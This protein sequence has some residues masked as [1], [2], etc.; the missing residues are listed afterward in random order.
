[1][2]LYFTD[3]QSYTKGA[4]KGN[5][6]NR[7]TQRDY[8]EC[9]RRC[10]LSNL[11]YEVAW[12]RREELQAFDDMS[13][14]VDT[15]DYQLP[16]DTGNRLVEKHAL[17]VDRFAAEH[18]RAGNL[19]Y[20]SL[21]GGEGSRGNA[22]AED[23]GKERCLL[24]PPTHLIPEVVAKARHEGAAGVLVIPRWPAPVL[25]GAELIFG[26][27][28]LPQPEFK[29]VG[30]IAG[31]RLIRRKRLYDKIARKGIPRGTMGF[32]SFDFR[33]AA[34]KDR[35]TK[36]ALA[37]RSRR[38]QTRLRDDAA[39]FADVLDAGPPPT[40]W[41]EAIGLHRRGEGGKGVLA[42]SPPTST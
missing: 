17:E 32:L 16:E 7:E 34:R 28:G 39:A 30:S 1:M 38:W 3:S 10:A 6:T 20:N 33:A 27:D 40:A 22:F 36:D 24:F 37:S 4:R 12:H 8:N 11:I 31:A 42:V 35:D 14:Y 25:P 41:W 21:L 5:F 13:K 15:S 26:A 23:W 29:L 2:F 19:P 18:S 9:R